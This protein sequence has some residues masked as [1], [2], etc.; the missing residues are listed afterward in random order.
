MHAPAAAAAVAALMATAVAVLEMQYT[1]HAPAA[2]A[3]TAAVHKSHIPPVVA[4]EVVAVSP[5]HTFVIPK[6]ACLK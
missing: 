2:A 1:A 6:D 4:A 5:L 3:T